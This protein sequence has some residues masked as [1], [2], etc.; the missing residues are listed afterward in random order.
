MTLGAGALWWSRPV[1]RPPAAGEKPVAPA[2]PAKTY[3]EMSEPERRAFVDER[4][5]EVSRMLAGREY[6]FP[7]DARAAVKR[8]VDLYAARVG[9]GET[10][11]GK[12]DLAFVF[13]RGRAAA[14]EIWPP[15]RRSGVPLVVALYLPMI[16]SEYRVDERSQMGARGM[17]QLLP[18]TAARY[19][20]RAE[21]LE[22]PARSAEIAA[23]HFRDCM[24]E[25]A[26]DR[27][28]NALAL[29]AYNMGAPGIREYLDQVE[30]LDDAEAE[31]RFWALAG[32]SGFDA[33]DNRESPRYI[34]SF[35]AAAIVGET[36]SAFGLPMRPLST[37]AVA[38][39]TEARP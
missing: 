16:E 28:G 35:F 8:Q 29:A 39:A 27:M 3:A 24:D 12:E 25:F 33:L 26:S 20:A 19:G 31:L 5:R 36:P 6:Q 32:N 15:F 23:R 7:P 37:Y 4:A 1:E 9:T 13:E 18:A 17:F 21:E 14:P 11:F 30:A 2:A 22:S 34:T 10:R 38:P